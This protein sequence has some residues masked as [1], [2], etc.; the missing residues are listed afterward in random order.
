[1][2]A[3]HFLA[4]DLEAFAELDVGPGDHLIQFGL[5]GAPG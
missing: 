4:V 3:Q 2:A 1:M 5:L